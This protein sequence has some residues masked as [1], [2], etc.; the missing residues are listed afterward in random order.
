MTKTTA[1]IV[2]LIFFFGL[3]IFSQMAKADSL[4][5]FKIL[6]IK[7]KDNPKAMQ[8]FPNFITVNFYAMDAKKGDYAIA[9]AIMSY[10][11]EPLAF[12]EKIKGK[13][14]RVWDC[15][16]GENEAKKI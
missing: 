7:Y 14:T 15:R 11:K 6:I 8:R 10:R 16:K 13:M 3:F 9:V 5:G 1:I 2:I 4:D 12:Y